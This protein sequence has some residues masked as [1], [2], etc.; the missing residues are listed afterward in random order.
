[1]PSHLVY[2]SP[3]HQTCPSPPEDP[4]CTFNPTINPP[5]KTISKSFFDRNK[6]WNEK[7]EK[8]L[9]EQSSTVRKQEEEKEIQECTFKPDIT[10]S[11]TPQKSCTSAKGTKEFIERQKRARKEKEEAL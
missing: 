11:K 4:E 1:S 7:R 5:L 2:S 3:H 10:R 6:A 9:K 8:R